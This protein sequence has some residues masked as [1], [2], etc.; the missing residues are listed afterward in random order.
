M[1]PH[2]TRAL[3]LLAAIA[4]T[5]LAATASAADVPSAFFISKTENKN[6]VHFSVHMDD[7]CNPDG[8]APVRAYW[9]MLEKG[10]Q[11]TESLLPREERAY[12]IARQTNEGGSIRVV[13][14]AIPARPITIHTW[15]AADGTCA[16]S[17][18]TMIS[19]FA[20]RLY[21]IHVVLSWYGVDYL[22]LTGWRDDGAVIR[23][24]VKA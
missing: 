17:S 23:E 14:R 1:T 15:R 18:S 24:R 5:F 11:V 10:P 7:A 19:G 12:G 13:L 3:G 21:N 22:L 6:Q 9:R 2:S 20:G 4:T 16:S 8:V